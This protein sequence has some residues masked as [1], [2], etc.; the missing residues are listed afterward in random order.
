MHAAGVMAG[1]VPERHQEAPLA[2]GEGS[3]G[4]A[5]VNVW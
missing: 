1:G 3:D 5:G 4:N 2:E